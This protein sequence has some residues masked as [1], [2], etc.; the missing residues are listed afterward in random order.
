MAPIVQTCKTCAKSYY[1]IDQE[2]AFYK[3]KDLPFPDVCPECRQKERLLL[4]NERRLHKRTCDQCKKEIISTYP[5]DAPYPVY[6]QDC[7]WKW[8]G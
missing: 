2:V 5:A 3:K 7:F 1:I 6:C 4:R 8:M